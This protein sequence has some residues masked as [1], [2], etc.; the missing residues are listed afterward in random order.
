MSVAAEKS[1]QKSLKSCG[2][3]ALC[4]ENLPL[5]WLSQGVKQKPSPEAYT[6]NFHLMQLFLRDSQLPL[7]SN[8]KSN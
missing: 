2:L 8:R 7:V 6:K 3:L 1:H 4:L 5:L